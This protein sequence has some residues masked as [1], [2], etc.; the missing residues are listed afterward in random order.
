MP[1][2]RDTGYFRHYPQLWKMLNKEGSGHQTAA[3]IVKAKADAKTILR[4]I[5][6]HHPRAS[7]LVLYVTPD[8]TAWIVVPVGAGEALTTL[9]QAQAQT[10]SGKLA[11][12]YSEPK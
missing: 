4:Q 10:P 8:R 7:Y 9:E 1:R 12:A 5:A 11:V 6:A 3:D 2:H